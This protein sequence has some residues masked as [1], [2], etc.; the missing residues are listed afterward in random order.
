S[1]P[2][3]QGSAI[4]LLVVASALAALIHWGFALVASALLAREM[5]RKIPGGDFGFLVAGAYSG[6]VI[7]G[8]GLSSSIALVSA[9]EGSPMNFIARY[10]G[11]QNTP[12]TATL[13]SPMNLVLVAATLITMPVMFRLM[14]PR[15]NQI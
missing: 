2:R 11:Q 3:N 13:L 15:G 10:T 12:L 9:T 6:F 8:S 4:V 5:G 14:M 7:W 1:R